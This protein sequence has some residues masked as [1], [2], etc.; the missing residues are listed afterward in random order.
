MSPYEEATDDRD[1]ASA[2]GGGANGHAGY[3]QPL[4]AAR[5]CLQHR[6][7]SWT[8]HRP[9]MAIGGSFQCPRLLRSISQDS[10]TW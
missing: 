6:V 7:P 8:T 4:R 3:A 2:E 1:R 9:R 5:R 10:N